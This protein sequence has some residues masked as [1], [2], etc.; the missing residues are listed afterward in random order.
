[1]NAPGAHYVANADAK[2]QLFFL[3]AI[4]LWHFLQQKHST[5]ALKGLFSNN[6]TLRGC[7]S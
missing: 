1:M 6:Q 3:I 7:N 2:V 5:F 4:T